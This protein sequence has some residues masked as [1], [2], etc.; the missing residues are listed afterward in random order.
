MPRIAVFSDVH[1]NS[2]AFERFLKSAELDDADAFICLGDL[3]GYI[4]NPSILQTVLGSLPGNT[5]YLQGNHEH[6]VVNQHW[7]TDDSILSHRKCYETLKQ[8]EL[9]QIANE[10]P[11]SYSVS[12]KSGVALF[13]HGTPQD[14]IF[15]R[16][17]QTS[18]CSIAPSEFAFV[19]GG[20]THRQFSCRLKD[21]VY[22]NVGSVG[23]PRDYGCIGSYALLDLEEG[24]VN[25]RRFDIGMSI[26]QEALMHGAHESVSAVAY[27]GLVQGN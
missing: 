15:G 4:P 9:L 3:I 5:V 20:N 25:L 1:G 19:F 13:T 21:T 22:T 18:V 2:A 14:P 11:Q 17:T 26:S 23:L 12:G 7:Q 16:L 27:R 24:T 10:W 8:S 6:M